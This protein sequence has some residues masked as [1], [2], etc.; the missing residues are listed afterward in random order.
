MTLQ[1]E[2]EL[3]CQIFNDNFKMENDTDEFKRK[4]FMNPSNWISASHYIEKQV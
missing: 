4:A 3:V 2:Y 1:K